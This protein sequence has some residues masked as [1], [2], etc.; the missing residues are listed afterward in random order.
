MGKQ[1]FNITNWL[2]LQLIIVKNVYCLIFSVPYAWHKV[3]AFKTKKLPCIYEPLKVGRSVLWKLASSMEQPQ[4]SWVISSSPRHSQRQNLLQLFLWLLA[5]SLAYPRKLGM[6][7]LYD[8][9][10][11][12]VTTLRSGLLHLSHTSSCTLVPMTVS[13]SCHQ[14]FSWILSWLLGL[15]LSTTPSQLAEKWSHFSAVWIPVLLSCLSNSSTIVILPLSPWS[16]AVLH[17]C[18][19]VKRA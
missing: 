2:F 15:S 6:P 16:K 10:S 7:I 14:V 13:R 11:F 12:S 5:P 3:E 9:H 8:L 1:Y 19:C 4:R 18:A 17:T